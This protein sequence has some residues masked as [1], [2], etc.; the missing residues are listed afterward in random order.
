MNEKMISQAGTWAGAP[1]QRQPGLRQRILVVDDDPL[2]RQL[3]SEVLIYSGYQVD[4]ADDGAAAW[5]ALLVNDYDLLVTDNDM[6]KVTGVALLKKVHATRM[7]VPVIM[8]AAA[9]PVRELANCPWLQP[10]AMVLKPYSF[11]ELLEKVK[12]VLHATAIARAEM[13]PLPNWQ[14]RLAEGLRAG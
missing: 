10:A 2:I 6:P 12:E 8:T 5:D 13:V 4:A 7:A 3:N 11:D 14:G 1:L 9:L